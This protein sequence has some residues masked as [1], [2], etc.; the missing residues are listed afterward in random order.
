MSNPTYVNIRAPQLNLGSASDEYVFLNARGFFFN[1]PTDECKA[2]TP[3]SETVPEITCAIR[4]DQTL[5][6]PSYSVWWLPEEGETITDEEKI[7]EIRS[8]MSN[9]ETYTATL[10]GEPISVETMESEKSYVVKRGEE[11]SNEPADYAGKLQWASDNEGTW[12]SFGDFAVIGGL[13][14]GYHEIYLV[15]GCAVCGRGCYAHLHRIHVLPAC[16]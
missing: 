5:V 4:S 11:C 2:L 14:P 13:T 8:F 3:D 10:D 1:L 7:E 16:Q 9:F 15:A 6:I 12:Y